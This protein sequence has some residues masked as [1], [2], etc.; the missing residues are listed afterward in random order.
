M[1]ADIKDRCSRERRERQRRVIS[2]K[3]RESRDETLIAARV[4]LTHTAHW[5]ESAIDAVMGVLAIKRSKTSGMA[6]EIGKSLE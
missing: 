4:E 1:M 3:A 5:S 2:D 6:R